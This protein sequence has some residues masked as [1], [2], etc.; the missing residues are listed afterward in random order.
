MPPF[1]PLGVQDII[2]PARVVSGS[3]IS[4]LSF[5]CFFQLCSSF[6]F[7][8]FFQLFS[9]YLAFP[10]FPA[11]SFFFQLFFQVY[12]AFFTASF[13]QHFS[14]FFR[15]SHFFISSI[16]SLDSENP[17]NP[18]SNF[19]SQDELVTEYS[20]LDNSPRP[21]RPVHVWTNFRRPRRKVHISKLFIF[22]ER[23]LR[24]DNFLSSNFQ[25]TDR[26]IFPIPFSH[27]GMATAAAALAAAGR[28]LVVEKCV[29]FS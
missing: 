23:N 27:P 5:F 14:A 24:R 6:Q 22:H 1:L 18:I 13:F 20:R 4:D 25:L 8:Q 12:S 2:S 26:P 10:P 21:R 29:E 19:D 3:Q 9:A 28:R 16:R 15:F 7:S 17:I 11:F